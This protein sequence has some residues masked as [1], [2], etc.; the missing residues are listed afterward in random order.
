[1]F[2]HDVKSTNTLQVVDNGKYFSKTRLK[3]RP[4]KVR[5][6]HCEPMAVYQKPGRP[7]PSLR[8]GS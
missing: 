6:T 8:R 5:K 7:I 1:V 2:E 3:T 4:D